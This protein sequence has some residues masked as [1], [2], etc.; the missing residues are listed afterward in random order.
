MRTTIT[1]M[2][3]LF[4]SACSVAEVR[5]IEKPKSEL[6]WNIQVLDI[7]IDDSRI[8]NHWAGVFAMGGFSAEKA[9]SLKPMIVSALSGFATSQN[10]K[11][12]VLIVNIEKYMQVL[13]GNEGGAIARV[14]WQ[15]NDER[16]NSILS[17][18]F[19]AARSA[20]GFDVMNLGELILGIVGSRVVQ[21]VA[22][23]VNKSQ[24]ATP[25]DH[26]FANFEEAIRSL[27]KSVFGGGGLIIGAATEQSPD[28]T[29]VK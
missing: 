22:D 8:A 23:A 21:S 20:A 29:W 1:I 7:R 18:T 2:F 12:A 25:I 16:D 11:R 17:G 4:L 13:G 28:W 10:A 3:A 26:T 14:S 15:L 5:P 24:S 27:P 6:A 19:F 9:A